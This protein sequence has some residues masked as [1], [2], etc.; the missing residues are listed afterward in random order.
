MLI[1]ERSGPNR[2]FEDKATPSDSPLP[3][4]SPAVAE[5]IADRRARLTARAG[6]VGGAGAFGVTHSALVAD[7]Q[8]EAAA[9]AEEKR[10]A[11][12]RQRELAGWTSRAQI[13]ERVERACKDLN[14]RKQQEAPGA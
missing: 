10:H 6:V 8:Q 11:R 2:W 5:T 3:G 1:A 4:A 14:S 12:V 9:R 7:F 13:A